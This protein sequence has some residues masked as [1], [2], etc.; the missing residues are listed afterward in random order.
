MKQYIVDAFTDQIFS[1]N[2][3]AVCVL[4]HWLP[5]QQMQNLAMENNLSETAFIVPEQDGYQLRWFTPNGEIDFC[6]HATLAAAYVLFRFVPQQATTLSFS[7]QSGNITVQ[8]RA[9]C[10][11]M[12][13]PAYT[14]HPVAVTAEMEQ[15]IGVKPLEAYLDRDL[16]LVLENAD[17]VR[18]LQPDF[19]KLSQL[20]GVC[21]AVTARDTEY[22]C[23]SRV[24]APKMGIPED[25]VTGSTHCMIVP[26]WCEKLGKSSLTAL[27]A[28]RRSGVLYAKQCENR[29]QIAGK[30]VLFAVSE[31]FMETEAETK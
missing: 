8:K 25:P 3:A 2:P 29:I 7:T 6:G 21:I 11:E 24:F 22:D 5:E 30:A 13:F 16:L 9:D 18:N 20:D 31:I 10:Y 17:A 12:N 28:S 1:G 26:Y 4:E 23:I 19:A 15:A 14:C 27:Q